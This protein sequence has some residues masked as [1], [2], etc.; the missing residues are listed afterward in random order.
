M[1]DPVDLRGHLVALSTS[2]FQA[3]FLMHAY[4]VRGRLQPAALGEQIGKARRPARA[5]GLAEQGLPL[6]ERQLR[7][8]PQI[9]LTARGYLAKRDDRRSW[10]NVMHRF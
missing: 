1:G 8:Y 7:N 3:V 4:T 6:R 9:V 5:P 2:L 10:F